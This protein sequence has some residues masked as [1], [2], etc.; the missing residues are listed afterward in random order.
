MIVPPRYYWITSVF[1]LFLLLQP[2]SIY[3]RLLI[4]YQFDNYANSF[5]DKAKTQARLNDLSVATQKLP[6]FVKT[7]WKKN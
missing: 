4:A 3:N 5:N 2:R 7:I 6:D 1:P